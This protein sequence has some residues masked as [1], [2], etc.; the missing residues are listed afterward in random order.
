LENDLIIAPM[1]LTNSKIWPTEALSKILH[2]K[3]ICQF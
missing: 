1:D 2:E 3:T